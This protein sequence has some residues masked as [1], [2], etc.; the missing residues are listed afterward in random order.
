VQ[1]RLLAKLQAEER[2]LASEQQRHAA[3]PSPVG[4]DAL[5]PPSSVAAGAA[6]AMARAPSPP[7]GSRGPSPQ[8]RTGLSLAGLS[9]AGLSPIY[10]AVARLGLSPFAV[11]KLV[12]PPVPEEEEELLAE[13]GEGG[14]EGEDGEGAQAREAAADGASGSEA[15]DEDGGGAAAAE[16]PEAATWLAAQEPRRASS[17]GASAAEQRLLA[18]DDAALA[19]EVEELAEEIGAE[20][21]AAAAAATA[22]GDGDGAPAP[23]PG[24]AAGGGA[25]ATRT[26]SSS[27]FGAGLALDDMLRA[28]N[29]L[30]TKNRS[31]PDRAAALAALMA[32]ARCS[33]GGGG[34]SG[35]GGGAGGNGANAGSSSGSGS[36]AVG[37]SLGGGSV[38][39]TMTVDSASTDLLFG[40]GELLN[41]PVALLSTGAA[42]STAAH[43][44]SRLAG[45]DVPRPGSVA[46]AV[47]AVEA[48]TAA[49]AA[50]DLAGGSPRAGHR[51]GASASE[52]LGLS[53]RALAAG[54]GA[55]SLRVQ[56]AQQH[57]QHLQQHQ[58]Q[59]QQPA[60]AVGAA[61]MDGGHPGLRLDATATGRAL[62]PFAAARPGAT[63]GSARRALCVGALIDA[64]DG[65]APGPPSPSRAQYASG[66]PSPGA[67]VLQLR[68]GAGSPGRRSKTPGGGSRP[69]S[70]WLCFGSPRVQDNDGG[71]GCGGDADSALQQPACAAG[72]AGDAEEEEQGALHFLI[73]PRGALHVASAAPGARVERVVLAAGMWVPVGAQLEVVT[74]CGERHGV[75]APNEAEWAKLV[76]GLNAALL[77]GDAPAGGGCDATPLADMVWSPR[78]E[79][80]LA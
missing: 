44:C 38:A 41:V 74:A 79:G 13:E 60:P 61:G 14:E 16:A 67:R 42:P 78:V 54:G 63:V 40:G 80:V 46:A 22:G 32:S 69:G 30:S 18:A 59:Q 64:T 35:A 25:A 5:T 65:A 50:A 10:A 36:G 34:G 70:G 2:R 49:A 33:G 58:H 72:E 73:G 39:R 48:A 17:G 45:A 75:L 27:G 62:L 56:L 37:P 11:S 4:A 71:G 76:A 24:T 1:Q 3:A 6:A 12:P 52:L 28:Y 26:G 21:A 43:S 57:Q 20:D 55:A 9:L 53:P 47:A 23:A 29:A 31:S 68:A 15:G 19:L 66:P 51:R 77:L 8:A 7:S